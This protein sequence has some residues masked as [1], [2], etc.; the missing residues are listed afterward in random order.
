[1]RFLRG[2]AFRYTGWMVLDRHLP[3]LVG[4]LVMTAAIMLPIWLATRRQPMPQQQ[5]A[6]ILA[7]LHQQFAFIFA[8]L[9]ANGIVAVDRV[10]NYFRFY[11]AKPVSPLWF[12]GEHIV[13]AG[14]A[15]VGASAGFIAIFSVAVQPLWSFELLQ[16]AVTLWLLIGMPIVVFSTVSR[17]D[18]LWGIVP[19]LFSAVLRS[20][21][22]RDRSTLG[23]VLHAV[24]PPYHLM[25]N[26][27][28]VTAGGWVWIIAW[29][30]GFFTLTL[31]LLA[32][33]PLAED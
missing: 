32:R 24:L 6:T 18:W 30:L 23:D 7:Q 22:P 4:C 15:M 31:V 3:R 12:Y 2:T 9:L 11:L 5:A 29:A 27:P 16:R 17:H 14:V 8:L 33:R 20:R 26:E 28:V 10:Q 1:M 25:G 21:W 19:W 13:L